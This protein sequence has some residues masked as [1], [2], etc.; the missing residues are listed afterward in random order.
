MRT[1]GGYRTRQRELILAV[2]KEQK[3]EHMTAEELMLRLRSDGAAVGTA[4]V[5]RYLE[6]L[7]SEGLVQKY[8]DGTKGGARYSYAEKECR[9]HFHL[10]CTECGKLFCADCDFLSELKKHVCG[11]H[12]FT[13]DPSKTVFY[14]ICGECAKKQTEI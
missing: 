13:I 10:K 1:A 12:G 14:G 8:T 9:G 3:D 2:L 11:E 7:Y 4:T 5:Y 6:K